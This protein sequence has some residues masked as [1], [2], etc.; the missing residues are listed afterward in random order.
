[1][2]RVTKKTGRRAARRRQTNLIS[3]IIIAGVGLLVVAIVILVVQSGASPSTATD[4]TSGLM[5]TTVPTNSRDHIPTD[6]VPVNYNNPPAGGAHYASTLPGKFYLESDVA[7]LPPHPEGYLTHNLEHG[8]VIFWYDCDITTVDCNNLQQT[9]QRV[10]NAVGNTKL[11][12]FPWHHLTVPLAMS[13]WGQVMYFPTL[14]ENLMQQFVLKN[15]YQAP[16]PSAQ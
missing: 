13:S 6:Q 11:I 4:A 8:Y 1:M 7:T 2:N 9:I 15:R 3:Y 12:A 10:M 5:G 14:D 16:E